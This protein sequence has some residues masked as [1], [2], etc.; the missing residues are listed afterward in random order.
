VTGAFAGAGGP[1][2]ATLTA[3]DAIY[4]SDPTSPF[5]LITSYAG[6]CASLT[7]SA[8]NVK[9]NSSGLLFD[10]TK[11]VA[12]GVYN[13]PADVDV[14]YTAY[15]STCNSPYG[16]SAASG[17]VTITSVSASDVVGT[18][19]LVMGTS[20][21]ITGSFTAATCAAAASGN[22]TTCVQ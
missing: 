16:E 15:D 3:A 7:A 19:N 11:A 6:V 12:A 5:V 14:Q 4:I 2:N 17:T 10:F 22:G 20:D 13:A 9:A 8:N 18:F 1:T 21:T